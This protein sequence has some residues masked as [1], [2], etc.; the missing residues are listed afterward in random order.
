MSLKQGNNHKI[1]FTSPV[2]AQPNLMHIYYLSKA[3]KASSP[4]TGLVT[5]LNSK[6]DTELVGRKGVG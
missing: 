2:T 4:L 6:Y 1:L 5:Q 3:S